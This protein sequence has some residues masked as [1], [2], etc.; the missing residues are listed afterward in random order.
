MK[1]MRKKSAQ[2]KKQEFSKALLV[3][4]SFL[5]WIT[6]IAFIILAYISVK[7][8]YLGELPWLAALVSA[9]WVAYGTSQA[10]YY[11]KAKKE[12]TKGGVKYLTVANDLGIIEHD[13]DI[14]E[15]EQ[16]ELRECAEG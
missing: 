16:E 9:L 4:E 3:Q 8:Q 2:R 11:N 14:I 13:N 12:N 15:E 1:A 7:E 10:F 6:T 5:V